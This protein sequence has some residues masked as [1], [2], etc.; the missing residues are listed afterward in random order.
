MGW[1][2]RWER[3]AGGGA[4]PRTRRVGGGGLEVGIEGPM[5]SSELELRST[6]S[7]FVAGGR[8]GPTGPL[9]GNVGPLTCAVGRVGPATLE[10]FADGKDGPQS[11]SEL[12]SISTSSG[13]AVGGIEGPRTRFSGGAAACI[14][15]GGELGPSVSSI[16]RLRFAR[17]GGSSGPTVGILLVSSYGVVMML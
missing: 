7:G 17:W 4:G 14:L 1:G 13:F 11:S 5:S 16:E 9:V 12:S 15:C 8:V 3:G 6:S 2:G 10:G